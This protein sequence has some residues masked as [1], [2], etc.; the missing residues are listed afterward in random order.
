[1]KKEEFNLCLINRAIYPDDFFSHSQNIETFT[2]W[3]RVLSKVHI[4]SQA[5]SN[6]ITL[7]SKGNIS[8]TL[9]PFKRNKLI[10]NLFFFIL[11]FIKIFKYQRKYNFFAFQASDPSSGI[12][13]FFSSKFFN[14]KFIMEIQGDVFNLPISKEGFWFAKLV[15]IISISLCKKANLIRVVSPF[16]VNDLRKIGINKQKIFL[17]PPRCNPLIF[18][19]NSIP[20]IRPKYDVA[21]EN[22]ILFV[23]NINESKGLDVLI[24]ALNIV[25]KL[26]PSFCLIVVGDGPKREDYAKLA[27]SF[28]MSNKVVF[29]DRVS[30]SEMP[31]YYFHSDIVVL[32]SF[33]EGFG[34]VIIE[35]MAMK[36]PVIGS[37]TGG[38]KSLINNNVNGLVFEVGNYKSLSRC[39]NKLISNKSLVKKLTKNAFQDFNEN[40]SFET[41]I[42]KFNDM[43]EYAKT[44]I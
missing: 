19:P 10:N 31:A 5:N 6:R 8:A 41:S 24:K 23:G 30:Y 29:V 16:L 25:N 42:K 33:H 2:G 9:I 40:Y 7:H 4:I 17:I 28:D 15:R 1:M 22:K 14:K 43:H 21:L 34:R 27:N 26:N 39:I 3:L 13:A 18:D 11:G 36:R 35:A 44:Q 20:S 12:L 37:Y 38:I 32:P